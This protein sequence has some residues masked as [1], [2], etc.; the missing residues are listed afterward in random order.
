MCPRLFY[1][2]F[3]V[4]RI[5]L[6]CHTVRH[7][8]K[9]ETAW[10]SVR[11]VVPPDSSRL[12][13]GPPGLLRARRGSGGASGSASRQHIRGQG[14]AANLCAKTLDFRGLDSNRI[15]CFRDWI[16]RPIG[17]FTES[18]SQGILVGIIVVGRY[19]IR[20]TSLPGSSSLQSLASKFRE[21][22]FTPNL[23]T[24]NIPTK[25]AWLRISGECSLDIRIAP[26]NIKILL[27]SNPPKSRIL[28]WRLAVHLGGFHP[29]LL[30]QVTAPAAGLPLVWST[31]VQSPY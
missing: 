30:R 5:I 18:L 13:L 16:L 14:E 12:S 20:P 10:G 7:F 23:P 3:V 19:G 2:F 15:L 27:E 26:F 28:V 29:R 22:P 4:S 25:I 21:T 6:I 31:N 11:Q 24:K 17:N 8:W 1:G 9:K